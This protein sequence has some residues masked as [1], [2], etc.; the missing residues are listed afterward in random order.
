M[1]HTL[2]QDDL[3]QLTQQELG[4]HENTSSPGQISLAEV[5][6]MSVNTAHK[7]AIAD[8]D[9][10]G[11][12][13]LAV[14]SN[15][16]ATVYL[17]H[18]TTTAPGS[19]SFA[20][21]G[22][23]PAASYLDQIVLADIDGDGR[24][25]SIV[26][27]N[28][29]GINL[30]AV[31]RNLGGFSFG[32]EQYFQISQ[33]SGSRLRVADIDRDGRLDAIVSDYSVGDISILRNNSTPGSVAF[34][35][36]ISIQ[37]LAN[38]GALAVADLDGDGRP[39]VVV[40]AN[41]TTGAMSVLRNQSSP[42]SISLS[43]RSDNPADCMEDVAIADLD[44]DGRPDVA[45]V[46]EFETTVAVFRQVPNAAVSKIAFH[47]NRDG[48]WEIYVM[49]SDG[50]NQTRL[51]DNPAED[52]NV[53]WSPDGSKL[54]FLSNRDG[55]YEIY[56][57][58]ADGSNPTRLTN[59]P[60]SD[61][62]P[63]SWSP[64]ATKL[65]FTSTRDG[66]YEIYV[67]NADGTNP[68]RLTTNSAV[69]ETPSWSP[70]GT[71]IAFE[72]ERTGLRQIYSMNSDGSNQTILT[73]ISSVESL[74]A[75]SPDG[76][77]IA[78]TRSTLGG[79]PQI[80]VM[81]ADGSNQINVSNNP[82]NDFKPA[83]SPDG[84]K[85]AFHSTG[86][87]NR[88]IY[89]MDSDGANRTR[90]T[91]NPAGDEMASWG[92]AASQTTR[93]IDNDDGTVTDNQTGL[94]WEKKTGTVGEA[95]DCSATPCPDPHDVNNRYEWCLDANNDEFCDNP[96]AA[97]D[98]GV[99]TDFLVKLNTPPCFAGHCDWRLPRSGG[100]P[101]WGFPSGEPF[102]LESILLAPTRAERTHASIRSS[103]L[104]PRATT[105]RPRR[106]RATTTARGTWISPLAS[107]TATTRAT[108]TTFAQYEAVMAL[109]RRPR[110][111]WR[112]AMPPSAGRGSS[113]VL[114]TA[115]ASTPPASARPSGQ[116]G[117]AARRAQRAYPGSAIACRGVVL[118]HPCRHACRRQQR[119]RPRQ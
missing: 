8:L 64:D 81:D 34:D 80:Y 72:S 60:A 33:Q 3:S 93:Y 43:P 38:P 12:P 52:S 105:G 75:W 95:V 56:T 87:G 84:T 100:Q 118:M 71:R 96:L 63:P 39:D 69:D 44:G 73:N 92:Y 14:A 66:N 23:L 106:A 30:L 67:M 107:W 18:N 55:N 9:G 27:L 50:T 42:G 61:E 89:V 26:N 11:R 54:A 48:N 5:A 19:I 32:A 2:R 78:F 91:N 76:L 47:S 114:P 112:V 49:N 25:D 15:S 41:G 58:N 101:D 86:D 70:D 104:R 1:D 88:E 103:D 99:S 62:G 13:D 116:M 35:P 79:H 68:V 24:P 117:C 22:G 113:A 4:T 20:F 31:R 90:L 98:G 28:Q 102:E 82:A 59:N 51:T 74:P 21:A 83:W 97:P 37:T 16:S 57:M 6:V 65:A 29:G 53:A 17:F 36:F 108:S 40:G 85:L 10:D 119:A 7:V 45:S 110:R 111:Q 77:H 115:A 46:C 94:Q 109:R